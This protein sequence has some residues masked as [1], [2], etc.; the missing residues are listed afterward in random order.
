MPYSIAA[1]SAYRKNV[2][3]GITVLV[4]LVGLCWMLLKFGGMPAMLF[5]PS[6]IPVEFISARAD[7]LGEGSAV[8]FRGVEVGRVT[9]IH[10][11]SDNTEIIINAVI[12][13]N[14]PLPGDLQGVIKIQ[15]L[16]GAGTSINLEAPGG[17]TTQPTTEPAGNGAEVSTLQPNQKI[18]A[19]Y[20]GLDLLPP[21]FTN[22]AHEL[23]VT[24]QELH[25]SHM[26]EHVNEAV[27]Q[28]RDMVAS[29]RQMIDNP[30]LRG[31]VQATMDNLKAVTDKANRIADNMQ[32]F[33]GQLQNISA[34]AQTTLQSAN[35]TIVKTQG[36]IDDI[37]R[38]LAD[39]L[40][41]VAKI[42][43][44]FQSI[45][46]KIDA[47]KGTAGA[48]INDPR[49]YDSLV[50]TSKRLNMTLAD[51]KRLIDQWEQE[52]IYFKISK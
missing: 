21:E 51:L 28:S 4:A 31:D 2:I 52:G 23:T 43:D 33:S 42:L 36:H 12:D 18:P 32:K 41:Q 20:V 14:P 40:T 9:Q 27:I 46:L 38:Q 16:L 19:T 44:N 34:E 37:T 17:N 26:I 10:R 45:S 7:G 48:L 5:T 47:G 6:Q 49:L 39:R 3:V 22:L 8:L 11:S 15:S 50:D 24:A 25:E 1:M 13:R 29:L 35:K 30:K